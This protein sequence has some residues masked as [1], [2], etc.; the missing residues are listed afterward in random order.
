MSKIAVVM[1]AAS[2]LAFALPGIA[3]A[4]GGLPARASDAPT[5]LR[6]GDWGG[7]GMAVHVT[8]TGVTVEWGCASGTIDKVPR[9]DAAGKFT[10]Q[11]QYRR[12]GPG[13]IREGSENGE[14]AR[15]SGSVEG[16]T[17]T[18]Q[19]TRTSTG[20]DLGSFTFTYGKKTR[21]VKCL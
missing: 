15:Y 2:S 6:A 10:A 17:L 4:G 18:L 16:D 1:F 20:E 8:D 7:S 3:C 14:P 9:L 21:I 19:V 11:G 13:P 12:D 5:A